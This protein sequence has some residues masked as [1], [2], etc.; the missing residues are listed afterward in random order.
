MSFAHWPLGLAPNNS[1]KPKPLRY[2]NNMAEKACHV[3]SS[4]TQF[5]LTQAL[6]RKKRLP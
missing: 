4:T 6:G 2:G 1:F 3:V 5:G